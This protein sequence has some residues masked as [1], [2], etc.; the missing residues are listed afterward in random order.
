M[1]EA[2]QEGLL[3]RRFYQAYHSEPHP[4]RDTV[5]VAAFESL[6]P[7]SYTVKAF[8]RDKNPHKDCDTRW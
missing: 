2:E 5:Y 6:P 3:G 8:K 7:G 4:S 1:A